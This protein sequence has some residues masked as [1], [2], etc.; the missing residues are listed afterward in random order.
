[1]VGTRRFRLGS[2]WPSKL[3]LRWRKRPWRLFEFKDA[4]QIAT[5]SGVVYI[6]RPTRVGARSRV[7]VSRQQIALMHSAKPNVASR[8]ATTR[9]PPCQAEPLSTLHYFAKVNEYS[10]LG[11]LSK[12]LRFGELKTK[13]GCAKRAM[14]PLQSGTPAL[15][16]NA[17]LVVWECFAGFQPA[18]RVYQQST[19]HLV[20]ARTVLT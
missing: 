12:W 11:F 17:V 18:D 5:K 16:E 1:V 13:D 4:A 3:S 7:V 10:S 19:C 14:A 15:Q 20:R 9:H 8:Q 6:H 2:E